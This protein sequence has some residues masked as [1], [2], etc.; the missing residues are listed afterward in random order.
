[1]EHF[2]ILKAFLLGDALGRP[3]NGMRQG[4]VEQLLG[5]APEGFLAEPILFP[6][7]PE[8]NVLP[9]LH[10][11]HGQ[12][13][14]AIAAGLTSKDEDGRSPLA[15]AGALT[16]ELACEDLSVLRQPGRPLRES[17]ARWQRDFPWEDADY[18]TADQRSA[19]ISAAL[20]AIPAVACEQGNLAVGLARQT[21]FQ[22]L[23][24]MAAW[25]L[26]AVLGRL[27]KERPGKKLNGPALLQEV[28][29]QLAQREIEYEAQHLRTWK[30]IGWGKPTHRLSALLDILPSLLRE[31]KDD[32]AVK[33]LLAA[34]HEAAGAGHAP[35]H[36]QHGFAPMALGWALY[37]GLGDELSPRLAVEDVLRRGGE[38]SAVAGIVAALGVARYGEACLP[39]EWFTGL[40]FKGLDES[41]MLREGEWNGAEDALR[42][43]VRKAVAKK[44][45]LQEERDRAA[46]KKPGPKLPPQDAA[47]FA[48]PPHLWLGEAESEDPE[49]KRILKEARGKRRIDWK[50]ERRKGDR[51]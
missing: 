28:L 18:E 21:H 19:G 41:W 36:V 38:C 23:P 17:L 48:P 26:A 25:L 33:S 11:V 34:V 13:A 8:R 35:A 43:P 3:F 47:P 39:E 45:A 2:G 5:A 4:H 46:G 50:E 16:L 9:G 15:R 51:E 12:R 29:Q 7:K 1:M 49:K 31:Q 42:E 22:S 27:A 24:V 40:R 14:L 44:L 32:L 37:R 20:V 10:G 30:E 6:E